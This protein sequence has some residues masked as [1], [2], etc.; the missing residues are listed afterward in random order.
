MSLFAL[1]IVKL[2]HYQL[3]FVKHKKTLCYAALIA[4][5][6]GIVSKISILIPQ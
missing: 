2:T 5:N 3:S 1:F 4:D 6:R